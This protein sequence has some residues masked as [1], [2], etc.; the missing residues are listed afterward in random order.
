MRVPK[1]VRQLLVSLRSSVP[2]RRRNSGAESG[3]TWPQ[4]RLEVFGGSMSGWLTLLVGFAIIASFVEA[5]ILL[6]VAAV[7]TSLG[8]GSDVALSA[9][10]PFELPN[11]TSGGLLWIAAGLVVAFGVLETIVSVISARLHSQTG[12]RVRREV[13]KRFAEA[14]WP[15]KEW[16]EGP[17][18]IQL[19]TANSTKAS[20]AVG[21]MSGFLVS[22]ANFSV[23]VG[24]AFLVDQRAALFVLLLIALTGL[25]TIPLS[26]LSRSH[27]KSLS[28]TVRD[29]N[30][31]VQEHS[32]VTRE[33]QIFGVQEASLAETHLLNRD[34]AKLVF[35]SRTVARGA[36]TMFRVSAFV[37]VICM[38]AVAVAVAADNF[39]SLA[40]VALILIR[41]VSHGQGIQRTWH[42]LMESS[43]WI[44]QLEESLDRLDS[45]EEA[46]LDLD[47]PLNDTPMSLALE[48][49]TFGYESGHAV[50]D[51]VD[52]S[53]K[54]GSCVGF[55]GGSGSGKST[56]V[57]LMLGLRAPWSGRVLIDGV[58]TAPHSSRSIPGVAYLRQEP[59]LIRGSII[60]N[61]RFYRPWITESAVLRS[62]ELAQI[63]DDVL[64][65]PQGLETDPGTLG[66]RLSGGQ[67][68]RIALARALAGSP[69]L[70]VLDEPT[71]ALDAES[72][73]LVTETIRKLRGQMTIILVGHRS[74]TLSACDRVLTVDAGQVSEIL[75]NTDV[76]PRSAI[77]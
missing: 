25:V 45:A 46:V 64:A 59:V 18:L 4:R 57:E 27:Q 62:L 74:S 26:T 6:V 51:N 22:L 8:L 2:F 68:Q 30:L 36:S 7:A 11:A 28:G 14:S 16:L 69:R 49:V 73:R 23:L 5:S 77:A 13:L 41:A 33:V 17:S 1:A 58:P 47:S 38:L 40:G 75:D 54:A 29:Y 10:G 52:L 56:L 66:S 63:L 15:S 50:L 34:Q 12:Y 42:S 48:K 32:T 24:A 53:I 9:V 67:K 65:W 55:V 60:E 21:F 44:D 3:R 72:D 20:E 43:P 35:N 61:V 37:V 19:C 76:P 31:A 70:L 71:S 39:S